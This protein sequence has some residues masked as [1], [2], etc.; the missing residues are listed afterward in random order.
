MPI[1]LSGVNNQK[2]Y[3]DILRW[4]YFS[5]FCYLKQT[6][7]AF[8]GATLKTIYPISQQAGLMVMALK[9]FHSIRTWLCKYFNINRAAPA[10]GTH[11]N[12]FVTSQ[13]TV[14][15]EV[16][17]VSAGLTSSLVQGRGLDVTTLTQEV[18]CRY[19]ATEAA[20]SPPLGAVSFLIKHTDSHRGRLWRMTPDMLVKTFSWK[21]WQAGHSTLLQLM[22]N[23]LHKED[24]VNRTERPSPQPLS[25]GLT[26]GQQAERK[27]GWRVSS[28]NP[29]H[30]IP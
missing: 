19:F 12:V 24:S 5:H 16:W 3:E 1:S 9:P 8:T 18:L 30:H 2:G 23:Y 14:T 20:Q 4:G 22:F 10:G 7:L 11:L 26:E 15:W 29:D 27:R 13:L 21:V 17:Y 6:T 25:P 28:P